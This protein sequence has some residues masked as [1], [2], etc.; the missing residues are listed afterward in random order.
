[1]WS[2]QHRLSI[3]EQYLRCNIFQWS[4]TSVFAWK[5]IQWKYGLA[6]KYNSGLYLV[7]YIC[8]YCMC[9]PRCTVCAC[10]CTHTYIQITGTWS[11]ENTPILG[12]LLFNSSKGVVGLIFIHKSEMLCSLEF[13]FTIIILGTIWEWCSAEN[14]YTTIRPWNFTLCSL[15]EEKV[16]VRENGNLCC[17]HLYLLS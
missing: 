16:L 4:L 13:S 14:D 5:D 10:V 1:M 15:Q 17:S 7:L 3:V 2:S 11:W 9:G 6:L 12:I 8:L